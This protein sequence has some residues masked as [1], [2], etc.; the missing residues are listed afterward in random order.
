MI[1]MGRDIVIL[2]VITHSKFKKKQKNIS[3]LMVVSCNHF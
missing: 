2:Y 1:S 3:V